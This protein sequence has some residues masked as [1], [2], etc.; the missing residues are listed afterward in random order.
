[1]LAAAWVKVEMMSCTAGASI[2][3]SDGR[4]ALLV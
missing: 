1:M 3:Q 2:L 4:A